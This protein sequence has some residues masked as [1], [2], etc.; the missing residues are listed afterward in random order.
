MFAPKTSVK[1]GSDDVRSISKVRKLAFLVNRAVAKNQNFIMF[2]GI[3]HG[4][5]YK[6]DYQSYKHTFSIRVHNE[7]DKIMVNINY[8]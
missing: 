3:L 5:V 4:V 7:N 2:C 6:N 8:K 1:K